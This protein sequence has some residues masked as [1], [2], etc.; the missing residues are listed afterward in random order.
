MENTENTKSELHTEATEAKPVAPKFDPY[1][2]MRTDSDLE[3]K[4]VKLEYNGFS[5]TIARAGGQNYRFLKLLDA[6]Q[7]PYRRQIDT[8]TLPMDINQRLLREVY[9]EAIVLGWDG[10]VDPDTLE[11]MPYTVAN[12][13]KLFE[14]LPE[15]FSDIVS[16]SRERAN[17]QLAQT[18][19]DAKN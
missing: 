5:I 2:K 12:C 6:K 17:F 4:G 19:A 16:M 3:T 13:T 9:A 14:K 1:A 15:L 10:V 18:E 11:P 8:D 7:R